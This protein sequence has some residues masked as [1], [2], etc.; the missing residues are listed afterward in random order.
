MN[1]RQWCG[2]C[3]LA[4]LGSLLLG[5]S[6]QAP[7]M[8]GWQQVP[9]YNARWAGGTFK[10]SKLSGPEAAVYGELQEPNVIRFFRTLQT[11]QRVYEWIYEEQEQVV[12][13]V[14]GQRVDY[15]TLD[16]STSSL[17]KERRE[18]IQR[19]ATTGGILGTAIGGFAAGFLLLG[20]DLGLRD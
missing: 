12:W 6:M 9:G 11:R 10:V 15:V 3:G 13:F 14:D 8:R 16:T 20:Q 18:T 2:V 7:Y 17:T 19:K 4:L 1:T 5:C